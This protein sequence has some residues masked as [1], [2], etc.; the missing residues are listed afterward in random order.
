M[1]IMNIKGR[2]GAPLLFSSL[3]L[4]HKFKTLH[5]SPKHVQSSSRPPPS[6]FSTPCIERAHSGCISEKTGQYC[7]LFIYI[8]LVD[9]DEEINFTSDGLFYTGSAVQILLAKFPLSPWSV[10]CTSSPQLRVQTFLIRDGGGHKY[11]TLFATGRHLEK[12]AEHEI[13]HSTLPFRL[14][15]FLHIEMLR[16]ATTGNNKMTAITTPLGPVLAWILN[17]SSYRVR[18]CWWMRDLRLVAPIYIQFKS[19]NW[20]LWRRTFWLAQQSTAKIP[21]K[22]LYKAHLPRLEW[23]APPFVLDPERKNGEKA[24]FLTAEERKHIVQEQ[25]RLPKSLLGFWFSSS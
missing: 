10:S 22:Q 16:M 9:Q 4:S 3:N 14:D 2:V 11:S 21:Y 8:I 24:K 1:N 19:R 15:C 5:V 13:K 20:Y 25:R 18:G 23:S 6:C 7:F 17:T 12:S